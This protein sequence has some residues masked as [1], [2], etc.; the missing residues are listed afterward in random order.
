[1]NIIKDEGYNGYTKTV[2]ERT[3]TC[4]GSQVNVRSG[5]STAFSVI[6]QAVEGDEFDVKCIYNKTWIEIDF[7]GETGYV[8][9]DYFAIEE[10]VDTSVPETPDIDTPSEDETPDIT[11]PSEDETPEIE[12]P[13]VD[14]TPEI[15]EPSVNDEADKNNEDK[16]PGLFQRIGQ[17]FV[18]FFKAIGN[19]FKLL[20][21]GSKK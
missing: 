11:P 4:V 1:M 15:E 17:A 19:F 2:G 18:N 13:S 7:N 8:H 12:E 5:A 20:F 14:A 9:S 6:G 16:R 3:A 10:T 21:G